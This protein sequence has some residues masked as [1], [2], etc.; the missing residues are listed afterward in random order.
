MCETCHSNHLIEKPFDQMV[1]A[2]EPAL[3]INCHE[4]GDGNQGLAV[5]AAMSLAVEKLANAH[6]EARIALV[7][8]IAKAK[9]LKS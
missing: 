5:A 2:K 6:T 7:D 1:G 3:C 4:D 9:E 8:A